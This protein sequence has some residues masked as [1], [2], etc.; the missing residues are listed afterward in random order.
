MGWVTIMM[1][2]PA[3]TPEPHEAARNAIQLYKQQLR[4]LIRDAKLY[5]ISAS[6]LT[7]AEHGSGICLNELSH[8][9]NSIPVG[10]I[11]IGV[12]IDVTSV[13]SGERC[14]GDFTWLNLVVRPLS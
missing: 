3:W 14:R 4:P 9:A 6:W 8:A 11:D 1:D 5:H 2:T 12:L 10:N 13:G 7:W